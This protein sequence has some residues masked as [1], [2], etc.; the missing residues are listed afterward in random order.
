[1]NM[2]A[3]LHHKAA[4][5]RLA[6]EANTQLALMYR[7][8]CPA[9]ARIQIEAAREAWRLHSETIDEIVDAEA[10]PTEKVA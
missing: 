8:L 4:Y 1:M 3:F 9:A 6:A 2:I 10:M 5:H 7:H